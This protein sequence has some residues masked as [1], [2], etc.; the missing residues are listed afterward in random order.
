VG[1]SD[2]LKTKP[3]STVD[4]TKTVRNDVEIVAKKSIENKYTTSELK[5]VLR[6]GDD[7]YVTFA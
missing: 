4:S 3:T 6:F 5:D 7:S 1:K 2:A